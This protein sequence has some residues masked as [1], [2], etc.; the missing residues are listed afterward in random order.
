MDIDDVGHI[1]GAIVGVIIWVAAVLA[2]GYGA[3]Y[4]IVNYW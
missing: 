3:H 4:I 1:V 2:M